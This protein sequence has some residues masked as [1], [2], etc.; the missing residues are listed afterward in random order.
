MSKSAEYFAIVH[1][2]DIHSITHIFPAHE[3]TKNQIELTK[4]EYYLL[5][6]VHG[7]DGNVVQLA[8]QMISNISKKI[9]DGGQDPKKARGC[10]YSSFGRVK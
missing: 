2:G 10:C 3:L 6:A 4:E 7:A 9:S 1:N 8:S 5:R